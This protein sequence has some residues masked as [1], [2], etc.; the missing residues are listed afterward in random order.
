MALRKLRNSINRLQ[1][2]LIKRSYYADKDSRGV[3]LRAYNS[4]ISSN[5]KLIENYLWKVVPDIQEHDTKLEM[6]VLLHNLKLTKD[7]RA[8][9]MICSRMEGILTEV[10]EKKGINFSIKG[11]PEDVKGEILADLDELKS[12]YNSGCYRSSIILCGRLLEVALHRKYFETTGRDILEKN[13]GIGLGNLVKKLVEKD[14]ELDPGLTQQIHL[15]NHVRISSVHKKKRTF[16]PSK[17]QTH[18][19]ILYTLDTLEKIFKA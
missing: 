4:Q 10:K 11:F 15:I 7:I 6:F 12:C 17:A 2:A 9:L 1:E 14:V 16:K 18:A 8:M 3:R 19:I 13:P 5:I